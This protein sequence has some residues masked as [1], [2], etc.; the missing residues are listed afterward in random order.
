MASE[1]TIVT[2]IRAARRLGVSTNGHPYYELDT[3]HGMIRTKRDSSIMYE[4]QNGRE[5]FDRPVRIRL[6]GRDRAWAID[7][8]SAERV[9]AEPATVTESER[10]LDR[11]SVACAAHAL[12]CALENFR[13]MDAETRREYYGAMTPA[14]YASTGRVVSTAAGY[15]T[16]GLLTCHC[17]GA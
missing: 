7:L 8:V 3:G 9:S 4:I 1:S 15:F 12:I 2:V 13:D 14:Q 10:A 16:D 6:D 5:Y 17:K 11:H